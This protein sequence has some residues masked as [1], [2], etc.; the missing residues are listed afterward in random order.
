MLIRSSDRKI[1]IEN[2]KIVKIDIN[3]PIYSNNFTGNIIADDFVVFSCS[4]DRK[5]V[6]EAITNSILQDYYD[7]Y[8]R[9]GSHFD[10]STYHY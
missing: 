2:P 1:L 4:D 10:F 9:G 6:V 3:T 5:D 7:I 8:N